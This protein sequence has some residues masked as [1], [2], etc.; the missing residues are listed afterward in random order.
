MQIEIRRSGGFAGLTE[1]IL[2]L[3]SQA[4]PDATRARVAQLLDAYEFWSLPTKVPGGGAGADRFHFEIAVEDGARRHTVSFLDAEDTGPRS[5][6][7]LVAALV[8]LD[9]QCVKK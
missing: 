6:R 5:L 2:S 1:T 3:D 8:E 4:L 9:S 7:Q